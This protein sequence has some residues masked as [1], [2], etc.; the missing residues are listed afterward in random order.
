MRRG[1]RAAK[2]LVVILGAL[3]VLYI[4]AGVTYVMALEFAGF[5]PG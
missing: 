3:C 4:L 5:I 1:E 2:T